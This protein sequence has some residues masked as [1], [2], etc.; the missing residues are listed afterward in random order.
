MSNTFAGSRLETTLSDGTPPV[1]VPDSAIPGFSGR[2][3]RLH[4]NESPF[5]PPPAA[6]KA[7]TAAATIGRSMAIIPSYS[8]GPGWRASYG[9]ATGRSGSAVMS[10]PFAITLHR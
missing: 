9:T 8:A 7:M 2:I 4:L 3:V 1:P 6:I 10:G 5:P